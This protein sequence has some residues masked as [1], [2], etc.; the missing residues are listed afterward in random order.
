MYGTG[1]ID[2][3]GAPKGRQRREVD[4]DKRAMF[5]NVGGDVMDRLDAGARAVNLTRAAYLERLVR[6]M[7]VDENGLPPWMAALVAEG[8][9]PLNVGKEPDRAAA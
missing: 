2:H 4:A 3:M 9:L 6:G 8:Q 7:P 1:M 5:M